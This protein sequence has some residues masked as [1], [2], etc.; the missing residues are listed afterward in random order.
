MEDLGFKQRDEY[1]FFKGAS[2]GSIFIGPYDVQFRFDRNIMVALTSEFDHYD[3]TT[4][5]KTTYD[6]NGSRKLIMTAQAVIGHK[7]R[8]VQV[9]SDDELKL[10]FDNDH[11]ISLIRRRNGYESMTISRR[12]DPL[13]VIHGDPPT[14]DRT[15]G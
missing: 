15:P 2:L 10:I 3:P 1:D 14:S 4:G 12:P 8:D 7:V 9:V 6:A 13:I 5:T 11:S